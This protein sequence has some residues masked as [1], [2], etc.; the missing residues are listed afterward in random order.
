MSPRTKEQNERMRAAR[1][2]LIR[3]AAF[4]VYLDRGIHCAEM[5]EIAKR[6]GIARASIYYYYQDK[7]ELFRLL[8]LGFIDH[9]RQWAG[10]TLDTEEAPAARLQRHARY[11]M[12][13][14]AE[15]PS[16]VLLTRRI[17][18]DLPAVFGEHAG[19]QRNLLRLRPS[20]IRA[21][22]EGMSAGQLR[23]ADPA[24]AADM[25]WG[26]LLGAMASLSGRQATGEEL[27]A[28]VNEAAELLCGGLLHE[29]QGNDTAN[30]RDA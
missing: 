21:F 11:Y 10:R 18:E 6:A 23:Q 8:F 9:A 5:N 15:D 20:L 13:R 24:L 19:E 4:D 2:K 3:Q 17:D 29:P 12:Q 22:R 26:G 7:W 14:A 25:Y 30:R 16:F 27:D 28:L 1:M